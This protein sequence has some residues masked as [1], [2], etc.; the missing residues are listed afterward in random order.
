MKKVE[1]FNARAF[2]NGVENV[3]S[4]TLDF[5]DDNLFTLRFESALVAPIN[6]R[7]ILILGGAVQSE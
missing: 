7:E 5:A 3:L 6:S 2:I 1:R 4:E